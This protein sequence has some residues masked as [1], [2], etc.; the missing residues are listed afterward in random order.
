M[1]PKWVND[2]ILCPN[3]KMETNLQLQSE[4]EKSK[5]KRKHMANGKAI[6]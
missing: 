3:L 4:T 5:S 1:Q 2:L 6:T